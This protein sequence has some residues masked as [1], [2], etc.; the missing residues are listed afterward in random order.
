MTKGTWEDQKA[1]TLAAK[2]EEIVAE[3]TKNF[4]Y[5]GTIMKK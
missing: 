2:P 1:R 5:G 3:M 4:L